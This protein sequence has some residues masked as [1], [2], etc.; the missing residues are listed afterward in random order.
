MTIREP[1]LSELEQIEEEKLF[2]VIDTMNASFKN[3]DKS[4]FMSA[5][6]DIYSG[7]GVINNQNHHSKMLQEQNNSLLSKSSKRSFSFDTMENVDF[8]S[9]NLS[10]NNKESLSSMSTMHQ[11]NSTQFSQNVNK[12]EN[13]I[14]QNLIFSEEIVKI[15]LIG[16]KGVGKSR[17]IEKMF[18]EEELR[19]SLN[20]QPTTR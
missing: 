5:I 1:T 17:F 15:I 2:E 7:C 12:L 14:K 11:S 19:N 18:G 13:I 20:Y 6:S 4:Q 16:D 8:P 10:L 3:K 9:I